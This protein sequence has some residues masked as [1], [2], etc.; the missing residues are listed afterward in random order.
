M[1]DDCPVFIVGPPGSGKSAV[2]QRLARLLDRRFVDTDRE[3]EDRCG[4]DIAYIF[5]KEGEPGFRK[6][7]HEALADLA[8]KPGHVIAT[9]GGIVTRPE[10]MEILRTNGVVVYLQTS[11]DQQFERTRHSK[12]RPLLHGEDPRGTLQK[13]MDARAPLY[14]SIADVTCC[15]DGQRVNQVANDI[16]ASLENIELKKKPVPCTR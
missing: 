3:V 6:R 14:E 16:H 7:E 11:V 15:T 5:E 9:G 8:A 12:A 4:V 1:N 13:L 2:G 10:N